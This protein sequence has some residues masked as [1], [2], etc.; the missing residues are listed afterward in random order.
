MSFSSAASA[1][2]VSHAARLIGVMIAP[3]AIE[4]TRMRCGASSCA[5]DCMK[6]FMQSLA[7]ELAPHRIRVNSIA[8]GAIMTPINRAAWETPEAL[9]ALL[10][11]IPYGRIGTPD[12]IGRA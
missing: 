6:S 12:D 9:A 4:L 3:G 1:S 7:Q 5:S 10:K 8:P 11:L 2:G